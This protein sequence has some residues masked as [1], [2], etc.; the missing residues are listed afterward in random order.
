MA[1]FLTGQRLT[2]DVL[3]AALEP[4]ICMVAQQTVQTGWTADALTGV[5]F[6][7]S[8]TAIDTDGIHSE[9]SNTTRLVIGGKLGWWQINGVFVPVTNASITRYRS[10]IGK[11]GTAVAGSFSGVTKASGSFD[12]VSTPVVLV[13]A[14]VSTDYVELFGAV[15]G[16]GTLGSGINTYIASSLT[17]IWV[18]PS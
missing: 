3:N 15:G 5:T 16:T 7:T 10:V 8:S 6:G 17:A 1:L 18:R 11:N 2:A 4:S 13:Q 12:G 14:T 9:S